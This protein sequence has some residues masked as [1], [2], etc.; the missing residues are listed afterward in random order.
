VLE[1]IENLEF[2]FKE[3]SRVVSEG[4][5]V[6]IGEL[7]PYKQYTGSKARFRSEQEEFVVECYT[8]HISEFTRLAVQNGFQ[9]IELKEFFDNNDKNSSPRIFT[10]LL[11]RI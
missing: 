11:K 10:L 9:I 4:G 2:A 6:Y 5:H 1:H 3:A 7:H 8:H